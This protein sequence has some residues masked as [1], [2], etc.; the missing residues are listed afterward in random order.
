[1]G[2]GVDLWLSDSY[3]WDMGTHSVADAKNRLS[4]LI[5][6]ALAGEEVV[7]SRHGHAVVALHSVGGQAAAM[8]LRDLDWL[9][10]RRVGEAASADAG[11]LVSEMRDDDA[12]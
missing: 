7:I 9:A 11:S 6:R 3:N 12:G 10:A 5:D 2:D 4:E 1:V 8:S